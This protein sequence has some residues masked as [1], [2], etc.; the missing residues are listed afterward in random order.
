M[1]YLSDLQN[2]LNIY[3]QKARKKKSC[4]QNKTTESGVKVEIKLCNSSLVG[5]HYPIS[6]REVDSAG[7]YVV[8]GVGR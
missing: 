4:S 8:I 1:I 7:T 6:G 5:D 3:C 2:D